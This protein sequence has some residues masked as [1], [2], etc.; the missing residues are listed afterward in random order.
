MYGFCIAKF[1]K[2]REGVERSEGL[3][4]W[5]LPEAALCPMKIIPASPKMDLPL[6]KASMKVV[7]S[8]G[9]QIF[10]QKGQLQLVERLWESKK[11]ALQTPRLGR[12]GKRRWSRCQSRD[13]PAA[14]GAVHGD[15]GCDPPGSGD[16]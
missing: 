16:P 8:L 9:Q 14:H 15:A 5:L 3:Q 7:A 6:A 4:G 12:K 13:Y 2:Q 11:K 1:W 10:F